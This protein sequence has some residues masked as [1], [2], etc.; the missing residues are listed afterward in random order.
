MEVIKLTKDNFEEVVAKSE[1]PVLIDFW[2]QWCGPCKMQGPI[3]D[4]LAKE[5]D[6]I[7]GGK[8][9]IDEEPE[10]AFRYKVMSIPTLVV[11]EKGQEKNRSVGLSTKDEILALL[12]K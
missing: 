4:E 7:V 6:D 2:A 1:K 12:S 10:L 5:K 11:F 9:D 8:I 3:V